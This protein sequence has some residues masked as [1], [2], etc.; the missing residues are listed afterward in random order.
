[1]SHNTLHVATIR[2]RIAKQALPIELANGGG[3]VGERADAVIFNRGRAAI[4]I[5]AVEE[6]G[7]RG[8]DAGVELVR[9]G[10]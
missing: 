3:R 10:L 1:M 2:K 9:W 5:C 4:G 8:D 6:T 7:R